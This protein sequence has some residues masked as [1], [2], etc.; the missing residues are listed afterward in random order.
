VCDDH[1]AV[2]VPLETTVNNDCA[3]CDRDG[4]LADADYAW[5]PPGFRQPGER[6]ADV[7]CPAMAIVDHVTVSPSRAASAPAVDITCT[8]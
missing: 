8:R 2:R 7:T 6:V 5:T 3:G 1:V 4:R